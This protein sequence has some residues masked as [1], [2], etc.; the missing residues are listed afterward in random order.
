M[1]QSLTQNA[2]SPFKIFSLVKGKKRK[3]VK[4]VQTFTEW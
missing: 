4:N 2:S 1:I 3:P